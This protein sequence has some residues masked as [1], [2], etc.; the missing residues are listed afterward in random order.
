M[1]RGIAL[2]VIVHRGGDDGA[3]K[4]HANRELILG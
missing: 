4:F 1:F 3:A 2:T